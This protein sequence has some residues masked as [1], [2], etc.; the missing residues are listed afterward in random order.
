MREQMNFNPR[1]Q[2]R[3]QKTPAFEKA[4]RMSRESFTSLKV[5]KT[6]EEE[7]KI[8]KTRGELGEMIAE[9][10]IKNLIIVF[11]GQPLEE[12]EEGFMN[13]LPKKEPERKEQ[14][15]VVDTVISIFKTG[16]DA[17]GSI[18]KAVVGVAQAIFPKA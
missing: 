14:D 4:G 16:I 2:T 6:E 15:P 3:A 9:N 11:P 18:M 7:N 1:E 17:A 5:G 12:E 13:I 8:N 10:R